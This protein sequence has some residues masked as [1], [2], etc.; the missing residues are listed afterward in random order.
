VRSA[1]GLGENEPTVVLKFKVSKDQEEAKA[2]L[3]DLVEQ[4]KEILEC[5]LPPEIS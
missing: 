1:L 5:M 2:V 3:T 4:A